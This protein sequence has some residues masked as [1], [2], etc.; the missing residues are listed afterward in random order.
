M[1]LVLQRMVLPVM[2]PSHTCKVSFLLCI[3]N[4]RASLI[5]A[6]LLTLAY[7]VIG[8]WLSQY[9]S[10]CCHSNTVFSRQHVQLTLNPILHAYAVLGS[11]TVT[12][13]TFLLFL[14]PEQNNV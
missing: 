7:L 10:V 5:Y 2:H 13:T 12:H 11:A 8:S 4:H 3:A 9:T 14:M 6:A 1:G